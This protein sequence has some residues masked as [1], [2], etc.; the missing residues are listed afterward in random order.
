MKA[1]ICA[2]PLV[3]A[4]I[5]STPTAILAQTS[6]RDSSLDILKA[7]IVYL[8]GDELKG[9]LP[10]TPGNEEGAEYIA[11]KFR[12][13]GLRPLAGAS[14]YFSRFDYVSDVAPGPG[15]GLALTGKPFAATKPVFGRTVAPLG[16]SSTGSASGRLFFVGYGIT[17]EELGYDD[18]AGV[19]VRGAIVVMMRQTPDG[20]APHGTFARHAPFT[21][22]VR[23]AREHGVAGIIFIDPPSRAGDLMATRLDRMF[24]NCGLPVM[25]ASHKLFAAVR[26]GR[27]RSIAKLE[28]VI[29]A[30]KESQSFLIDGAGALMTVDLVH[31]QSR[32]ANIVGYLPGTDPALAGQYI[33]VGGHMDHLGMGGHGSLATEK[34]PAVHHG[35]DDNASGTSGV[36]ELARRFG[37]RHSNRRPIIFACFN[38]EEEGL[39]GSAN[40]VLDSLFPTSRVVAMINMDMIGRLDSNKLIVQGIGSSPIWEELVKAIN[41]DRFKL[42]L[43]KEA[44]GP[45]DHTSF[46]NKDIPVLFFFTGTHTDYHR[47]GDTWE[48]I[49]YA[50]LLEVVDYADDIMRAIDRRDAPVPFSKAPAPVATGGGFRVYVGTIP[51][52]AYDGKGLRLSGVADGGP[53]DKGGMKGGDIMIR[54]A[55]RDINNIYDYTAALGQ[56][57]PKDRV[58]VEYIRN[59]K[60]R[61]TMVEVQ[62]R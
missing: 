56:L 3:L 45:S 9:R 16:F 4:L 8:A 41:A 27:K 51:D 21:E 53:A 26:D 6:A 20:A 39:I 49:N 34:G 36:L 15:N 29:D 17:A 43:V 61:K 58:E 7:H 11:R 59:G 12:E 13:Y 52:Y 40:L 46:Y 47:P 48:K 33:V 1:I 37:A 35:A 57:K 18:Y 60:I 25:F 54:F 31:R 38:A 28:R 19:D 14:D 2:A 32:P 50:G 62:E 10:G 5:L 30:L 22:K 44:I 23:N 42:T 55:R 24:T